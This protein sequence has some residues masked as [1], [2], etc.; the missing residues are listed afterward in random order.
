MSDPR[1]EPEGFEPEV[2][3]EEYFIDCC[4]CLYHRQNGG[5]AWNDDLAETDRILG[6]PPVT[7]PSSPKFPT[8]GSGRCKCVYMRRSLGLLTEADAKELDSRMSDTML[9]L[10]IVIRRG[11]DIPLRTLMEIVNH[12]L[13]LESFER[14][15]GSGMSGTPPPESKRIHI[16]DVAGTPELK[17]KQVAFVKEVITS[18]RELRWQRIKEQDQI[19]AEKAKESW[20]RRQEQKIKQAEKFA[21]WEKEQRLLNE[22]PAQAALSTTPDNSPTPSTS[23][24]GTQRVQRKT[25]DEKLRDFLKT[26]PECETLTNERLAMLIGATPGA[27]RKT[28]TWIAMS[29]EKEYQ[30]QQNAIRLKLN[31]DNLPAAERARLESLLGVRETAG[32]T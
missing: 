32:E 14:I 9:D 31:D 13:W 8:C 20:N 30:K 4:S 17:K 28:P 2:C 18:A 1:D 24:E 15:S 7:P 16:S 19:L 5:Q 27:V 22:K 23:A 26:H 6:K 12:S 10:C 21:L 11:A 3:F 29:K 25:A